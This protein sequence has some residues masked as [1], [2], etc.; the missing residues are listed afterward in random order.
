MLEL[1][2]NLPASFPDVIEYVNDAL[3]SASEPEAVATDVPELTLSANDT[4][5]IL[6]RVGA[7][8]I[9]LT[10]IIKVALSSFSPLLAVTV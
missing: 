3:S 10:V 7:S 5:F 1:I 6:A 2:A 4:L 9:P 8:L